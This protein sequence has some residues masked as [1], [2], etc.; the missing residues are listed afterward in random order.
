MGKLSEHSEDK[1]AR[2]VIVMTRSGH[3]V[4]LA[5]IRVT[6]ATATDPKGNEGVVV[7][8][9]AQG[10]TGDDIPVGDLYFLSTAERQIARKFARYLAETLSIPAEESTPNKGW[11]LLYDPEYE[12]WSA[13]LDDADRLGGLDESPLVNKFI[14][15]HV[16][17]TPSQN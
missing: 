11:R 2:K 15:L 13:S 1:A 12:A 6:V 8:L 9:I 14:E 4:D 3:V 10:V 17:A 5:T 7:S 16:D